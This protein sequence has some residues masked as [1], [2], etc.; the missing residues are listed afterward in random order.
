MT[1]I[2][3]RD[4]ASNIS[5]TATNSELVE[6]VTSTVSLQV[7]VPPVRAQIIRELNY[8]TAGSAYNLTCLVRGSRPP[9]VTNMWVGARPLS[10]LHTETGEQGNVSRSL[11]TFTPEKKDDGKFLSCRAR[12]E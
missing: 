6:P 4:Q 11:F 1:N 5:C 2:S 12:N 9:P 10:P 8:F 3:S 7:I